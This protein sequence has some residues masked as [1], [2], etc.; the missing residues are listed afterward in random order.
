MILQIE[1]HDLETMTLM[2]VTQM[3]QEN[4]IC[5]L[6]FMTHFCFKIVHLC[7]YIAICTHVL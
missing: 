4:S 6:F 5:R 7:K 2:K 3:N 1:N